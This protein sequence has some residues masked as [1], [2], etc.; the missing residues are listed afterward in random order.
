VRV[1]HQGD[2]RSR[3]LTVL[4]AP[5]QTSFG[6]VKD[7]IRHGDLLKVPRSA[8]VNPSRGLRFNSIG[9]WAQ[10]RILESFTK[11]SDMLGCETLRLSHPIG[12]RI[13]S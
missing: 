3:S 9:L 13:I 10:K 6:A 12:G 4:V 8:S 11:V 2:G 7:H 5:L 1:Q